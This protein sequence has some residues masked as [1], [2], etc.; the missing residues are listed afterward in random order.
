MGR[1]C[2]CLPALIWA[3]FWW[4]PLVSC[5]Q[6]PSSL[7]WRSLDTWLLLLSSHR[8]SVSP[9]E[10]R[11]RKGNCSSRNW[12]RAVAVPGPLLKARAHVGV[13]GCAWDGALGPSPSCRALHSLGDPPSSQRP[14]SGAKSV[15]LS[16]RGRCPPGAALETQR[17]GS[18]CSHR[19]GDPTGA[20]LLFVRKDFKIWD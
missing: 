15:F 4:R 20:S 10:L 7:A 13:W 14:L 2:L 6:G 9:S 19:S 8:A 1:G 16:E 17:W 11:E 3:W 12:A 18:G 5:R